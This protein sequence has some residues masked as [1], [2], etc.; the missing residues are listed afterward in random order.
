MVLLHGLRASEVCKLNMD[1]IYHD[2]WGSNRRLIIYVHGKGKKNR[3]I[4]AE[5]SGDTEWAWER[6]NT[7]RLK[8]LITTEI[9]LPSIPRSK[10]QSPRRMTYIALYYILKRYGQTLRIE[11]IYPHSWRH[12]AAVQMLQDGVNINEIQIRLGHESIQ[13]T[14]KYLKA[15]SIL[16]EGAAKSKWIHN[17]KKADLRYRRR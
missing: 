8:E 2:G 17:L 9:C 5:T 11:N 6:W 10:A 7:M 13:T 15:A 3:K 12:T 1:D 4:V 16:Q 14:E